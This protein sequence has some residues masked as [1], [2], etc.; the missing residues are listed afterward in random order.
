MG[1]ILYRRTMNCPWVDIAGASLLSAGISHAVARGIFAGIFKKKGEFV[2]TPKGWKAK[3]ALAFFGPI[4]EEMGLLLALL[5]CV[6]SV[7]ATLGVQ[8]P[9]AKAW[10]AVLLFATIP[11][12]AALGCQIA[13]Y[14]PEKAP[15]DN[16]VSAA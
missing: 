14:W 2:V 12:W 10:V 9:A 3:R 1:P 11:Y 13:S 5:A 6:V 8:D 7:S 16:T 15:Q 4:R